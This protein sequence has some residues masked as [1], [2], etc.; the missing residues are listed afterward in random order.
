MAL[1]Q[2]LQ[3]L[4]IPAS[5]DLSASQFCFVALNSSGQLILPASTGNDCIGV[6]QDKPNAAGLAGEVAMLNASLRI[7]VKAAATL[8]PGDKVRSNTAGAAVASASGSHVLGT[9]LTGG[10]SGDI[11]EILPSSRMLLP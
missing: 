9:V 3:C 5:A 10:V 2:G 8:N 4:S 1:K 7:K 6:L 11:I